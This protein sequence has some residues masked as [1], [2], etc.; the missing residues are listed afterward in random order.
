M[1]ITSPGLVMSI[2]AMFANITPALDKLQKLGACDFTAAA[3]GIEVKPG[4]TVKV[5]ISSVSSASAFDTSSNHY[6]TG[7]TT[8]YADLTATH[9]LQGFDVSGADI[10]QG[11]NAA[12]LKNIFAKRA[13]LGIAMAAM[14]ALKTALDACTQSSGVTLTAITTGSS[15]TE[16]TITEYLNLGSSLTWLNKEQSVL[17][18][19]GTLLANI[20]KV[21]ATSYVVPGSSEELAQYLGFK[22]VVLIPGMTARACIVP[23]GS[24]GF[25]GRV[26]TI[27]ANYKETGVE[28]DPESGLSVGIVVADDQ[29]LNREIVNADLW[30]GVAKQSA[31]ANASTTSGIIK[32]A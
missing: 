16:P 17:A 25:I 24:L 5:P 27:I 15:A 3:P 8:T 31:S 9:Y 12:R 26:P 1:A 19:N 22:D 7:G 20:K 32:I 11:I 4:A 21:L 14:G 2:E 18:V 23:P 30:F 29:S 6:T 13:G 28:T 10:D